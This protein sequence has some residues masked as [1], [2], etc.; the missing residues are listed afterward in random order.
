MSRI[1]KRSKLLLIRRRSPI[2]R[3]IIRIYVAIPSQK[4][5]L[6]KTLNHF[7]IMLK[8]HFSWR[9]CRDIPQSSFQLELLGVLCRSI[10]NGFI[11]VRCCNQIH[12]LLLILRTGI[13]FWIQG[14]ICR[15]VLSF[16]SDSS[17]DAFK[18]LYDWFYVVVSITKG[19]PLIKILF[20]SWI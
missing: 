8:F 10:H 4:L 16:M 5:L 7:N 3:I 11:V 17:K 13:V 12:S 1:N 15:L 9:I 20:H 2:H 6:S 18:N 19:E 14:L